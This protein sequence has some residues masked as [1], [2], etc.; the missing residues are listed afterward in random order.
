MRAHHE[1]A[2]EPGTPAP[3]HPDALLWCEYARNRSPAARQ[4]LIEHHMPYA[5]MCAARL[6]SRRYG[7]D[8]PFEDFLHQALLGLIEAVDRFDPSHK[9]LFRSFAQRRIEGSI[10]NA[11]P[12]MSE[13]HAQVHFRTRMRK[14]R[15]QSLQERGE[16]GVRDEA[17]EAAAVQSSVFEEMVELAVGLSIGY[18]LDGA[19]MYVE[20]D[21][22]VQP[23][24][25]R[26]HALAQLRSHLA[27]A[28]SQLSSN[29]MTVVRSH[30]FSGMTFE[31]IAQ[32]MQ[33]TSGRVS[34]LHKR[35]L[36]RLRDIAVK[37]SLDVEL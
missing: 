13:V 33:L 9:V 28:L 18:M 37:L 21:Q 26:G 6:Y 5:R 34:Q 14:E 30:Y 8:A 4:A 35:A 7:L 29:Q 22:T 12:T 2:D 23:D 11:L 19:A 25:Y 27:G 36:A 24:P 10:L 16:A 31:A 20:P 17:G 15:L 3:E 32:D 1:T